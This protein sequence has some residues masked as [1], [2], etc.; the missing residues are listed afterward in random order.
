MSV[1]SSS[2]PNTGVHPQSLLALESSN[3]T[4]Q[5][6]AVKEDGW[7]DRRTDRHTDG[8]W[9]DGAASHQCSGG[10]HQDCR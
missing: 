4:G 9:M 1:T 6:S 5:L 3:L 8:R 2:R 7:M 10:L